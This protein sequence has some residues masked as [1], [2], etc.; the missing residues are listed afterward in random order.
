MTSS[1]KKTRPN[2]LQ[3]EEAHLQLVRDILLHN[4]HESVVWAFG[5]RAQGCAKPHSDLD[6]AIVSPQELT[7]AQVSN[8][9]L[10]FEDSN[11]PFRVDVLV[12]SE[13]DSDFQRIIEQNHVVL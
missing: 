3:L 8:L 9:K 4:L 12:W 6:L 13:L 2:P 10:D 11:L 5:S 1:K 7:A